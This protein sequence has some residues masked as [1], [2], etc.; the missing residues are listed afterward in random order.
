MVA[1]NFDSSLAVGSFKRN[2][3]TA[4]LWG[5]VPIDSKQFVRTGIS[6]SSQRSGAS[7][8]NLRTDAAYSRKALFS[9]WSASICCLRN[10][11]D[12]NDGETG[13]LIQS[14]KQRK[15]E[16]VGMMWG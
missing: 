1:M 9:V 16:Q 15:P 8:A 12:G 2:M 5:I 13:M 10:G 3:A 4:C 14:T 6:A 7:S 11:E